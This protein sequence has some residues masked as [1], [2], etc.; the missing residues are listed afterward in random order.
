MLVTEYVVSLGEG[1]KTCALNRKA[2]MRVS[3]AD[4]HR[5]YRLHRIEIAAHEYIVSS[6]S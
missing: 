3:S 6:V 2:D 1:H 4:P 5:I